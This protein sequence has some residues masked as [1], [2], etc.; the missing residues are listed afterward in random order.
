MAQKTLVDLKDN[1]E[2]HLRYDLNCLCDIETV[3]DCGFFNILKNWDGFRLTRCLL[4]AGLKWKDKKMTQIKAG[5]IIEGYMKA[6]GQWKDI[7][8]TCMDALTS[9]GALKNLMDSDPEDDSEE[10]KPEADEVKDDQ[11]NE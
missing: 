7:S 8:K 4:W 5:T 11:G 10:E 9:S 2:H 6:G 1:K 3:F